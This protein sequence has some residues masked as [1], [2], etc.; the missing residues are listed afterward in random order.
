MERN[1][2][3]I[4]FKDWKKCETNNKTTVLN[5]L[6]VPHNSEEIRHA[7]ITK[8]N[9][10]RENQVILLMIKALRHYLA[11]KKLSALLR[12]INSKYDGDF[13]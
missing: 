11:V 2:F 8:H 13:Y 10:T 9:S 3:S 1:S 5:V 6:H 12:R 4:R 7:Y